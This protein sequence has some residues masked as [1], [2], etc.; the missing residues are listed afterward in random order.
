MFGGKLNK[1]MMH[2][3]KS[4]LA[5]VTTRERIS[6][7]WR[8]KLLGCMYALCPELISN[9][10]LQLYRETRELGK[11]RFL[12]FDMASISAYKLAQGHPSSCDIA[13]AWLK[14]RQSDEASHEQVYENLEHGLLPPLSGHFRRIASDP[15]LAWSRTHVWACL[16]WQQP[17]WLEKVAQ[18]DAEI[19]NSIG[20]DSELCAMLALLLAN[21]LSGA[22]PLIAVNEVL[23]ISQVVIKRAAVFKIVLDAYSRGGSQDDL[24]E[25]FATRCQLE[26]I[27]PNATALGS[28]I[29][30][31]LLCNGS[32]IEAVRLAKECDLL[33]P[34]TGALLGSLV[35]ASEGPDI[36]PEVLRNVLDHHAADLGLVELAQQV[37]ELAESA[38]M[39]K[40]ERGLCGAVGEAVSPYRT[41]RREFAQVRSPY[42]IGSSKHGIELELDYIHEPEFH[43]GS[44]RMVSLSVR[45]I[46]MH[47]RQLKVRWH[48]EDDASV[49]PS[50]HESILLP[51][52]KRVFTA[53]CSAHRAMAWIQGKVSVEC[54][55]HGKV[56]IPFALASARSVRYDSLTLK[57]GVVAVSDSEAIDRKDCTSEIIDGKIG[58]TA[59]GMSF[60][61]SDAGDLPHWIEVSLPRSMRANRIVV[62]FADPNCHP[63]DFSA[64]ISDD[65]ETW[66][67]IGEEYGYT[68]SS[69]YDTGPFDHRIK[70]FRFEILRS[71]GETPKI[72]K[73]AEIEMIPIG[74]GRNRVR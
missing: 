69:V 4:W 70:H 20:E 47:K 14:H 15:S 54:D 41:R 27:G 71:T 31:W 11:I 24:T 10:S 13:L 12:A 61:E 26:S 65:G 22:S 35:G 62:H 33:T 16:G 30:I 45:C 74:R 64:M 58:R 52:T 55:A 48:V 49:Y 18:A 51:G 63:S 9:P 32:L 2:E 56:E 72:A 19:D 40:T 50:E 7:S 57:P 1:L 73:I 43:I 59:D 66:T 38:S 23:S 67:S 34:S 6:G 42:K 44:S 53:N 39:V 60:W 46:D 37:D 17:K 29:L 36:V 3:A 5:H 28:I 25:A 8:G 21:V 68:N